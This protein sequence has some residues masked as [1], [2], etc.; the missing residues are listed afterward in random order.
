MNRLFNIDP[1]SLRILARRPNVLLGYVVTL[2][3]YTVLIRY[4][5][6]HPAGSTFVVT[7]YNLYHIT[8][9]YVQSHKIVSRISYLT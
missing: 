9:S 2:N 1:A 4:H 5:T 6:Q 3:H 7:S 8:F